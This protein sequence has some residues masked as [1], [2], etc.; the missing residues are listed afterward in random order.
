M[1]RSASTIHR[2]T[3]RLRWV[4]ALGAASLLAACP[5]DPSA[6]PADTGAV[7]DVSDAGASDAKAADGVQT[8]DAGT[9][10]AADAASGIDAPDAGPHDTADSSGAL[11]TTDAGD[12]QAGDAGPVD[13]SD[14]AEDTAAPPDFP[15][16]TAPGPTNGALLELFE[17][18]H[19]AATTAEEA[20]A[21]HE[22]RAAAQA[23]IEK[24]LEGARA[25]L[26]AS[27]DTLAPDAYMGM[28]SL[29][30]LLRATGPSPALVGA[31]S[32]IVMA[33]PSAEDPASHDVPPDEIKRGIAME[34]LQ[35]WAR[36]GD[37]GAY[38][39]IVAAVAAPDAYT[40]MLAIRHTYTNSADRRDAQR[41]M[42]GLL[43]PDRVFL[44]YR[45]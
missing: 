11:D 29:A 19:R 42:R 23:A 27:L 31:L 34:V 17:V 41:M 13:T 37:G 44:L 10:A 22:Q 21:M 15:F 38:G 3:T 16:K 1:A 28:A 2:L 24:D 9:D 14:G 25:A 20:T 8:T 33:P 5:D 39:A 35:S 4:A 40:A 43:S 6:P 18:A 7:L 30:P 36:A 26:L 45:Y 12:A 32:D